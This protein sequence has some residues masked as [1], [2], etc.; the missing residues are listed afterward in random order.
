ME[1]PGGEGGLV[2]AATLAGSRSGEKAGAITE[3]MEETPEGLFVCRGP[4]HPTSTLACRRDGDP[5]K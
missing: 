1:E 4:S 5:P 2:S 3:H